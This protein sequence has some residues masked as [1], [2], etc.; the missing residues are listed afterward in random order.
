MHRFNIP[1]NLGTRKRLNELADT[2][3]VMLD[4][5]YVSGT[6]AVA[7]AIEL[8]SSQYRRQAAD[9]LHAKGP[10]W[11]KRNAEGNGGRKKGAAN[12]VQPKS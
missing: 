4:G 11:N 6:T 3:S 12:F 10:D 7:I 2:M 1:E 8:V 9:L 5:R